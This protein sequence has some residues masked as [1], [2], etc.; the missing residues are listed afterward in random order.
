MTTVRAATHVHSEW[1]YHARWPLRSI[2]DQFARRGYDAV[3]MSDH[4]RG[5]NELRW[6]A[7]RR[8]CDEASDER[9]R[10]VPGIEYEDRQNVVHVGIWGSSVPFL[11]EARSTLDLLRAAS[12][13]GAAAVFG[14]PGRRDAIT[15]YRPEWAEH[16]TGV[17]VWNRQYDG[18]A[19]NARAIRFAQQQR[20]APFVSLDFHTRRQ[21]FPLAMRLEIDGGISEEKL[22]EAIRSG[23][24]RPEAFGMPAHAFS[25]GVPAMTLRTAEA[26]RRLLRAPLRLVTR[27]L[28]AS[29]IDGL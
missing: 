21:F 2:A 14:H 1:S 3:F 20:L 13:E 18:M 24:S 8:A 27:A 7:Y 15:R 4:E 23:R 9:I 28:N 12:S 22:I 26:T 17:E 25:D 11:G 6:R 16:L 19:P 29:S 10:L 5:F